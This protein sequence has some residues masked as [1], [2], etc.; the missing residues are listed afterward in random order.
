MTSIDPNAPPPAGAIAGGAPVAP[1][2]DVGLNL[3]P[4]AGPAT[5]A[6]Y[7][8]KATAAAEKFESFFIGQMLKEMRSSVSEFAEE[9]SVFKDPVNADML[10]LAD[11][12]M[13]DK[14]SGQHAFGIA[15]AILRQLLPAAAASSA[16]SLNAAAPA[17]ASDKRGP[18]AS[19]P[20]LNLRPDPIGTP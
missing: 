4:V 3:A 9:G 1:A 14:M 15:D 19:P 18:R 2:A 13:A 6:D 11:T 5:D 8:A 20:P 16:P 12:M 10:G 7:R 17:V